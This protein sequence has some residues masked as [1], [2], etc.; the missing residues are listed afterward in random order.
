MTYRDKDGFLKI[1][2]STRKWALANGWTEDAIRFEE[3]ILNNAYLP[4]CSSS[5]FYFNDST[6]AENITKCGQKVLQD[7]LSPTNHNEEV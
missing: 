3:K 1:D 4:V 6:V 5:V 7:M 2:E